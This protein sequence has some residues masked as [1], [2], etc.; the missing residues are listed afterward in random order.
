MG[1]QNRPSVTAWNDILRQW[2]DVEYYCGWQLLTHFA[3]PGAFVSCCLAGA[4]FTISTFHCSLRHPWAWQEWGFQGMGVKVGS[5]NKIR[6]LDKVHISQMRD[7][8]LPASGFVQLPSQQLWRKKKKSVICYLSHQTS[9]RWYSKA[10]IQL[11]TATA[12]M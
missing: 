9:I 8:F 3:F 5:K 2:A 7:Q 10:F 4:Q 12:N 6:N 1:A 11:P